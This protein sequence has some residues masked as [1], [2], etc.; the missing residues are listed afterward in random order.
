M[1][2]G[3]FIVEHLC[4]LAAKDSAARGGRV[5]APQIQP[6]A[7]DYIIRAVGEEAVSFLARLEMFG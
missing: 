1:D 2:C 4:G 7:D 5:G 6:C 3:G